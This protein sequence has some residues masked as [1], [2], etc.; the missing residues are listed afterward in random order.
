MRDYERVQGKKR[1][2]GQ[3]KERERLKKQC[4]EERERKERKTT[5]K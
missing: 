4:C 1:I 3:H 2:L 5:D